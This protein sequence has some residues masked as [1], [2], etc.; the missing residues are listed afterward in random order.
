M[1]LSADVTVLTKRGPSDIRV[2]APR[3]RAGDRRRRDRAGHAA[4]VALFANLARVA[5]VTK[6]G[7]GEGALTCKRD[8]DDIKAQLENFQH[9]SVEQ[10]DSWRGP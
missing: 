9:R 10:F 1:R 5:K 4:G 2:P 3:Y 8:S 7:G 6:I